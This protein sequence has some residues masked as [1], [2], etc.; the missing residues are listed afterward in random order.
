M[1][2]LMI[3]LSLFMLS[4]T[5]FAAEPAPT[6]LQVKPPEQS[7]V[8]TNLGVTQIHSHAADIKVVWLPLLAPLPYSFPRT[9]QEIPNALVLTGTQIPQRPRALRTVMQ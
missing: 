4:A 3:S 5:A 9:T 8:Q 2:R 6:I 7:R 1:K